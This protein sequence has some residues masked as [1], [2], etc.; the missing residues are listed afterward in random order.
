MLLLRAHPHLLFQFYLPLV[1][2]FIIYLNDVVNHISNN[3]KINPF[4][5][6]IAL[7]R[8]IFSL[9]DYVQLQVD[10]GAVNAYLIAKYI[11]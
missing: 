1:F 6:D 10:V 5:D 7:Y 8:V 2:F 3:S 11:N 4:A 9:D